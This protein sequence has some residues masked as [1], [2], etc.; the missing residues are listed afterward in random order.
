MSFVKTIFT[1]IPEK[2][3]LQQKSSNNTIKKGEK[4]YEKSIKITYYYLLPVCGFAFSITDC[5]KR[6]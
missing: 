3:V 6:F 2:Y 4:N 1:L 5:K